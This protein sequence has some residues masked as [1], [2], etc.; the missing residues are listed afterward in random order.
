MFKHL[1]A[2]GNLDPEKANLARINDI[3]SLLGIVMNLVI[4]IGLSLAIISTAYAFI[5]YILS[6]GDPK[7]TQKA[8]QTFLWG[9]IV[10][11]ITA[12]AVAIKAIFMNVIGVDSGSGLTGE[13][14]DYSP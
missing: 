14:P 13:M 9:V 7:N 5:L 11:A 2:P 4:G 10:F 6:S 3:P 8:W 1:D 12:G